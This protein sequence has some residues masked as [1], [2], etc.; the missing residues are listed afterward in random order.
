MRQR[1]ATFND[2][3]NQTKDEHCVRL[4]EK[5]RLANRIAKQTLPRSSRNAY[6]VKHKALRT[7]V[8]KMK[9]KC[10]VTQ[11]FRLDEF[12]I[13]TLR[14]ERLGLHIPASEL[15]RVA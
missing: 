7:I 8:S 13:V 3:L 4:M 14:S 6:G 1:K 15:A 11:D 2:I 9:G 5:A 10:H 12:K